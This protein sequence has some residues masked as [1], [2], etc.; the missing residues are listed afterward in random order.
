MVVMMM[1]KKKIILSIVGVILIGL[2]V[3][4]VGKSIAT[5]NS[6]ILKDQEVSGL[7]FKE[8]NL[9]VNKGISTLTVNVSNEGK[10]DYPLKTIT[11]KFTMNN[12]VV[13]MIGYV[14]DSIESGETKIL[15]ASM[16]K[17][18]SAATNLEYVINNNVEK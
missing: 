15:T 13:E 10:E 2:V 4:F 9:E 1:N 12:E 18:L 11:I 14:G 16:D 8:A 6:T 7:T 17:D 3:F 5:P